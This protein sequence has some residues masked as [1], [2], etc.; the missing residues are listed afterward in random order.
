MY[1]YRDLRRK[2]F[3]FVL[4]KGIPNLISFLL[5][6]VIFVPVFFAGTFSLGMWFPS[7]F[8]AY[9]V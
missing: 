3:A 4:K 9:P 2:S 1:L 5:L 6:P 7:F 8:S